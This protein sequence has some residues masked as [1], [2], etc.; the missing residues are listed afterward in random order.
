MDRYPSSYWTGDRGGYHRYR[1]AGLT[2]LRADF[3]KLGKS[4][5]NF[6]AKLE[7]DNTF[8]QTRAF[9]AFATETA[10]AGY[11]LLN[12]GIG[13]EV[14]SKKAIKLFSINFTANN[15][16]DVAYQNH[17]SRLK[18]TAVNLATGRNGVFNMGRNFSVRVN[19]PLIFRVKK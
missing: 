18:Y 8:K 19:V 9:T 4:I 11:S 2:E 1:A 3:K 17:L 5:S 10:T 15:I 7:L 13:A 16:T 6:Y 12:V 14:V